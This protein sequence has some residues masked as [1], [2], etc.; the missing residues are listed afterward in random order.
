[1]SEMNDWNQKIIEEFRA[2]KGIVGGPFA[3][4]TLLL[5]HTIGAK[6]GLPRINP[7]M[8]MADGERYVIVASKGGAPTDPDWYRN[9]VANPEA[10]IEIGTEQFPVL[11]TVAAEPERTQLYEKVEA[12]HPGFTEYK[13]KTTRVIPVII[14][15]RKS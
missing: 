9:I 11:A 8:C 10:S 15:T 4:S 12:K 13:N 3:G 6:S 1:M 7:L 5:L 14:L 2:N